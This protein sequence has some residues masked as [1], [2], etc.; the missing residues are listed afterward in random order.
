MKVEFSHGFIKIFKKRF[1]HLPN[2][3][4]KFNERT[5]LFAQNPQN[6]ILE[7]HA[8]SGKLEGHKAFS[9][10]GN[11]RV[12]YYEFENIAYFVDI[13]THNQVYRE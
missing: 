10:T 5:R 13:G 8:L 4:E 12:V 2:I 7:D 3:Q 1:S 11:I 6:P 9:V